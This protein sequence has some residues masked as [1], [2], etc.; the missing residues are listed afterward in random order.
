MYKGASELTRCQPGT[1][2]VAFRVFSKK[3]WSERQ[4]PVLTI[5]TFKHVQNILDNNG[6]P[7]T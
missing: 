7:K 2:L 5:S 1:E 6:F 4:R 3:I